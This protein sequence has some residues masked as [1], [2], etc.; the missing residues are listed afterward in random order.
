MAPTCME[1]GGAEAECVQWWGLRRSVCAVV[2]GGGGGGGEKEGRIG[3]GVMFIFISTSKRYKAL[4]SACV[5]R[6]LYRFLSL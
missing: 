3:Q 5:R 6:L 1:R 4:A 2:S